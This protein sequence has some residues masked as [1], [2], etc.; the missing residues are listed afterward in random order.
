MTAISAPPEE[1]Q[2]ITIP[3]NREAEEAVIGSVLISPQVF[4]ECRLEFPDG[5][6]EFYVH[7]HRWIW[8]VFERL[9]DASEPIDLIVLSDQ[10]ERDGRLAEIGGPA[11]LTSLFNQV[12]SA[13]NAA[14]Y[15]RIVHK[16]YFRRKMIAAANEVAGIA[17]KK[18][19]EISDV[20]AQSMQA[21]SRVARSG[22]R[23][24]MV[25]LADAIKKSDAI[26]T[27]NSERDE[28]PGIPTPLIDL[29][30]LLGGGAQNSDLHLIVGRP[31][32]GK[33]SFLMQLA[34][35]AARYKNNYRVVENHVAVFSLEMPH[36]QLAMRLAAQISGVDYQQI[37]S[38]RMSV[39]EWAAYYEAISYLSGL[40][41]YIDDTPAATPMYIQSRCELL[42][43]EGKL[44]MICVDSL[45]LM[46]SGVN[47]G[48]DDWKEAGACAEEM[49][50]VARNFNVPVWMSHQMNRNS[51][52]RSGKPV[53]SDLRDGGDQEADSVIF[54]YHE[55][56][57][58]GEKIIKNSSL[59]YEKHRNGP[60]GE[61]AVY[62]NRPLTKFENA[63]K[64]A[65]S[66]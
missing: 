27:E 51:E 64:V 50:N 24:R 60:T 6:Q 1:T 34:V 58:E 5:A 55:Y 40:N 39:D 28:L 10:L 9:S 41:L 32:Q 65:G 21:V 15:A 16:E 47:Y 2:E 25:P 49:K 7:R 66:K 43:A 11:Y 48:R 13:L 52:K 3:N 56:S 8:E 46:K 62:F 45:N 12:P 4:H 38:G 31:G 37:Q 54:I 14:A 42:A 59:I 19:N 33:T 26:T 23:S 17:Y 35:H 36:E 44:N 57:D 22:Q 53:L 20:A 30:R 18:E 61:V 29:N 63:Y